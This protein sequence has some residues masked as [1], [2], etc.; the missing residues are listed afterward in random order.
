LLVEARDGLAS[1]SF[2]SGA[3]FRATRYT[4]TPGS[5]AHLVALASHIWRCII[6][7]GVAGAFLRRWPLS[8]SLHSQE[9]SFWATCVALR[10]AGLA[11][12][13]ASSSRSLNYTVAMRM[14]PDF[15]RCLLDKDVGDAAEDGPVNHLA[16]TGG[17]PEASTGT[18]M[19]RGWPLAPGPLAP[20][21]CSMS[22]STSLP[23]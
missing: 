18:R 12:R 11:L 8:A 10:V 14:R 7:G 9:T 5:C 13:Q 22:S 4:P 16:V 15:C 2:F 6:A 20:A 1:S 3:C 17:S 21:L 19:R 23:V